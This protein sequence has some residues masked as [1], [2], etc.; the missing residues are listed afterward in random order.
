MWYTEYELLLYFQELLLSASEN[1]DRFPIVFLK[2]VKH[3]DLRSIIDFIYAGKCEIDPANLASCTNLAETLGVSGFH[4]KSPMKRKSCDQHSPFVK[5]S[6]SEPVSMPSSAF[7]PNE[8]M[9][10]KRRKIHSLDSKGESAFVTPPHPFKSPKLSPSKKNSSPPV[11]VSSSSPKKKANHHASH[12]S[13]PVE[14]PSEAAPKLPHASMLNKISFDSTFSMLDQ[15][16]LASRGASMLHH[17]AVWMMEEQRSSKANSTLDAAEDN[18]PAAP[19]NSKSSSNQGST[20]RRRGAG[21]SEGDRPDS[22]F[23][24]KD[25]EESKL[26]VLSLHPNQVSEAISEEAG[27]RTASSGDTSP[28][29]TVEISRQAAIRQPIFRKRRIHH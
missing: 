13:C 25:E 17:L 10:L 28:D 2:D 9:Q 27:I 18:H 15:T 20:N 8:E 1:E 16:E 19:P 12:M 29:V 24:S 14:S 22:G 26:S 5:W 3:C 11:Q 21:E 6:A 23:D 7:H 4:V